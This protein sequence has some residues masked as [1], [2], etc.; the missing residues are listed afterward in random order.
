MNKKIK[1]LIKEALIARTK[2]Y[3]PYSKFKVGAALET[4][5][6]KIYTGCNIENA[7]YGCTICAERVAIAKAVSEGNKK[8]KRIVVIA[9]SQRPC[10]PCGICR[11]M[12][13][14][15]A[16]NIEVIMA[17]LKGDISSKNISELLSNAFRVNG[18]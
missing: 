15:F 17:N 14:E 16:P 1:K 12:L 13:Y 11:Q 3:A 2:A 5:D 8:F 6:G 4:K 7:S 18:R 9:D 10:P